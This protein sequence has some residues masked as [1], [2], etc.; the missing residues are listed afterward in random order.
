MLKN[1]LC[2]LTIAASLVVGVTATLALSNLAL[3]VIN[4]YAI[5]GTLAGYPA[6]GMVAVGAAVVLVGLVH[7]LKKG[8]HR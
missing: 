4:M 2:S 5:R 3:M 6:F 7:A 8:V 1:L